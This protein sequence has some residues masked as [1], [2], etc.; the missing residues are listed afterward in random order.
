MYSSYCNT[1]RSVPLWSFDGL[2][3]WCTQASCR[4]TGSSV[5]WILMVQLSLLYFVTKQSHFLHI[6]TQSR[7]MSPG[8]CS[9]NHAPPKCQNMPELAVYPCLIVVCQGISGTG[10]VQIMFFTSPFSAVLNTA[11]VDDSS[12][13][14]R[15]S[16]LR[17]VALRSTC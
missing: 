17:R 12:N 13:C 10:K 7:C 3:H 14:V 4:E 9:G 8:T 5:I 6:S 2:E 1:G 11:G 15:R 16:W